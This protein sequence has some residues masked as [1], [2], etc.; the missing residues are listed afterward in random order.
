MSHPL[1]RQQLASGVAGF[2][3]GSAA[4]TQQATSDTATSAPPSPAASAQSGN[5][6]LVTTLFGKTKG[7]VEGQLCAFANAHGQSG[8]QFYSDNFLNDR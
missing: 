1:R 5:A 2:W 6:T 4:R 3:L 7:P 8:E